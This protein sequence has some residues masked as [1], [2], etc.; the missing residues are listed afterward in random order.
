MSLTLT[1]DGDQLC[2]LLQIC[3]FIGNG[4]PAPFQKLQRKMKA[5]RRTIFRDFKELA[6]MGIKVSLDGK[7]YRISQKAPACRKLI[8]GHQ[9]KLV[10]RLLAKCV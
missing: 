3:R 7:G 10:N 8:V 5:S 6:A 2:R 4:R 1:I 9:I